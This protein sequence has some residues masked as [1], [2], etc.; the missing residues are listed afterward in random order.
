[1]Y[2]EEAA[3]STPVEKPKKVQG[4]KGKDNSAIDPAT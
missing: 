1:M 3:Q 4:K 2:E